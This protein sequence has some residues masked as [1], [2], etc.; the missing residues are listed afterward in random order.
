MIVRELVKLLLDCPMEA[1]VKINQPTEDNPDSVAGLYEV[2]QNNTYPP[3]VTL[4]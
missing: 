1:K 4:S 2:T 3:E